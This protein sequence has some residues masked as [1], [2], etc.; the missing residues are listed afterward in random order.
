MKMVDPDPLYGAGHDHFA[1]NNW[2][3]DLWFDNLV[4]TPL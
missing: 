4:I 3:S 2:A 1:F